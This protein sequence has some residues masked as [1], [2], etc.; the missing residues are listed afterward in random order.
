MSIRFNWLK[1]LAAMV[2]ASLI[3]GA[4][5]GGGDTGSDSA[6][7]GGDGDFKA[8]IVTDT[9]GLGDQSFNDSANRGLQQAGEELG[10]E[11]QVYETSQPS[12]YEPSL[13]KAPSQGSDITFAIG[14]PK[15]RH[16]V[17]SSICCSFHKKRAQH[18][19]SASPSLILDS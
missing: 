12:D 11:T 7:G 19:E 5:G 1:L 16:T 6:S 3:V 18:T 8:A 9:A 17:S 10:I 14:F 2:L 4:C 15:P 13:A